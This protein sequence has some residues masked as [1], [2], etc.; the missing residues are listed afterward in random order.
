M[1]L[2]DSSVIV[3]FV[4]AFVELQVLGQGLGV[5]LTLLLLGHN[6]KNNEKKKKKNHLN[7]LKGTVLGDKE[8]GIRDKGQ[9]T[10]VKGQRIRDKT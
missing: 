1:A 9:G 4:V 3:D 2:L 6:N 10:R 8:K 5:E 7:F